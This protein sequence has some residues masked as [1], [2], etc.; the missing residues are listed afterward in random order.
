MSDK[1]MCHT[2]IRTD[3]EK[4]L[5]ANRLNRIEGQI[6]GLKSMLEDD[7][8]CIDILNQVAA[9]SAAINS[10]SKE[11]LSDHIRSCVVDDV[12]AGKDEKIEELVKTLSKLMK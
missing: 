1:C 12:L 2:K 7:V 10:F 6:R 5:L 8:Y 4:K 11:L 9:V 3:H